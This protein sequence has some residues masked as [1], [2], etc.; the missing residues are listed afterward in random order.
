MTNQTQPTDQKWTIKRLLDWTNAY[1]EKFEIDEP[2]L[3]AEILLAHVLK[4]DRIELYVK[5]DQCPSPTEI[6]T[7]K[8]FMKRASLHEPVAHLTGTAHFFSMTFAVNKHTLIPRPETEGLVMMALNFL[9][10]S[11][12]SEP[13]VLDL[14]TGSGC[15]AAAIANNHQTVDVIGVDIS[16]EACKMASTNIEKYGLTPRVTIVEGDLFAPFD[17]QQQ[18]D[19]I[20]ANPPYI[21]TNEYQALETNVRAYEPELALH[22]GTDGLDII[23]RILNEGQK[24]LINNGKLIIEIAWNQSEQVTQ[25]MQQSG[26]L[27]NIS[28]NKDTSGHLRIIEGTKI[29]D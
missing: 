28:T 27:I 5:F 14:C 24:K 26:W 25:L 3:T 8:Q 4:I 7:F 23:K 9:K 10:Q 20:T 1:F 29:S 2:R 15:V 6:A 12:N 17:A 13:K 22:G 21:N 18:F 11:G 16:T 19:V